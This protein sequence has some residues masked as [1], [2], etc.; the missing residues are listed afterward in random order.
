MCFGVDFLFGL[1]DE[2]FISDFNG[3]FVLWEIVQVTKKLFQE[4]DDIWWDYFKLS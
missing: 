3:I 2:S 4:I 1:G